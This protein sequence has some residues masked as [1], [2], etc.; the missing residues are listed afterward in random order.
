MI[1]S[2]L[3]AR[4]I[5]VTGKGGVGKS[6]TCAGLGR[7]LAQRGKRVLVVETDT[8]SAMADLFRVTLTGSQPTRIDDRLQLVN[9]LAQDALVEIIQQFVPGEKIARGIINNRIASVFFNAAPSVN[10]FVILN[11]IYKYYQATEGG[12]PTYDHIVVDLPASGHAVTF[13]HVP[14]TLHG[15]MRVGAFAQLAADIGALIADP[16]R[17]AVVAVCLPE[18][19]PVNETLEL[20]ESITERLHRPLTMALL[21]MV[22]PPPF[23]QQHAETFQAIEQ[24]GAERAL[25]APLVRLLAGSALAQEWYVRDQRYAQ[26]LRDKLGRP[27]IELPM[28]YEE[29]GTLVIQRIADQLAQAPAKTLAS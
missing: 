17:T 11:R 8:Y 26:I 2:L 23:D 9:L 20:A 29:D 25:D 28:F 27:I 10:E 4:L 14:Q 13:L 5:F 6:T 18:E 7:A 16:R 19:M 21:N 12:R 3:S 24:A 15:M 1:E 22:H